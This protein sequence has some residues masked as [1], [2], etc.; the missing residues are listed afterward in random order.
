MELLAG[1]GPSYRPAA[2]LM[3]QFWVL[4][5]H[6][7]GERAVPADRWASEVER[8]LNSDAPGETPFAQLAS[9]VLASMGWLAERSQGA[10]VDAGTL[11]DVQAFATYAPYCDAFTVDRR[12]A[13]VLRAP[14][15]AVHLPRKPEIFAGNELDRLEDWLI[16]V[17]RRAPTGH[18][19]AVCAIYGDGWLEPFAGILET[20]GHAC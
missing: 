1:Y 8:F 3:G 18:F 10:K 12:F 19:E 16:E 11:D 5:R 7:M 9:A 4:T 2:Q 15:M 6:A 14:P 17:E 20:V 13:H